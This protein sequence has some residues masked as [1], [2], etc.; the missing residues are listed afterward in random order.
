MEGKASDHMTKD[1]KIIQINLGRSVNAS[2]LLLKYCLSNKIDIAL[3]QEPHNKRGKLYLFDCY[4]IRCVHNLTPGEKIWAGIIIFDNEIDVITRP[5]LISPHFSVACVNKPGQLPISL[6]SGYF[7]FRL[8]IEKF[9]DETRRIVSK[10]NKR[11]ILGLDVNAHHETW[12]SMRNNK[13]GIAVRNLLDEIEMNVLNKKSNVSTFRGPMGSSNIDITISDNTILTNIQNWRCESELI[14]S[15]HS[16]I[17]F[18]INEEFNGIKISTKTRY[19]DKIINKLML[20]KAIKEEFKN[21]DY[22]KCTD[23]EERARIIIEV[24]ISACKKKLRIIDNCIERI[25]PPW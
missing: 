15:D 8:L 19:K 10:L 5:D 17:S 6:I 4:P 18:E 1:L 24:I 14:I 25:K 21:S 7:Q 2:D 20:N 16:L 13:K 22:Y 11:I 9:I 23:I 3:V 12:H